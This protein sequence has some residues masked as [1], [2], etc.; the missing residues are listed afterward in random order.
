MD[1]I[2]LN[3]LEFYGYHGVLPEE[4]RLG[5]RFIVDL[6]IES[7][8]KEAGVKDDLAKTINYADVYEDCRRIVEKEKY[9]LIEA[10]A[11]KLASVLL[12]KYELIKRVT[13]KV[14][15][16]DPPIPGHYHSVAVEI[17]REKL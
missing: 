13:V 15:K 8:L 1:K 6:I 17:I 14:V 7:D 5:Q 3:Q 4:N 2:Y 11:E 12:S 16:P 10:I 9:E